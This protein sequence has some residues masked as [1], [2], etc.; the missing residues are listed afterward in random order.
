M[1]ARAFA[2]GVPT[3][4]VTADSAYGRSHAFRRWLEEHGR[5][6]ALMVPDTHAVRYEGRR[7][8]AAKLAER[9]S[10]DARK[11]V[12]VSVGTPGAD[13]Q[14]W[15]CLPLTEACAPGMWRWLL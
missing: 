8:T 5:A 9:L 1:L 12:T 15:A 4:W 3:A 2:A 6:Y 14:V 13:Q 7:Q 11:T 10:D